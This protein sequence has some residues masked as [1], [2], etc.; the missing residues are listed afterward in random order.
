M[1][2]KC[3]ECFVVNVGLLM[4]II[5]HPVIKV[6]RITEYE[7]NNNKNKKLENGKM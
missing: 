2:Q 4:E 3:L 6:H 7:T 5:K 1:L